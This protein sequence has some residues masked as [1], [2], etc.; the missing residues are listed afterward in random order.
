MKLD[1]G[2]A[3]YLCNECKTVSEVEWPADPDGIWEALAKRPAP[4][5]RN[6]FPDSHE[7][8]LRCGAAHGQT[9]AELDAET[10]EHVE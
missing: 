8:A 5:N 4:R 6:W 3:G 1:P 7:L 2:Q 9:V 10:A